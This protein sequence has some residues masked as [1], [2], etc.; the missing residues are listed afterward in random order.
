MAVL[1]V[2]IIGAALVGFLS[3]LARGGEARQRISDPTIESTLAVRRLH[4][5]APEL[6][7]VLSAN[8]EGALL[9]ISD[10]VAS[11][12]VHLSEAGLVRFDPASQ[13]LLLETVAAEALAAD[14]LLEREYAI[15]HYDSLLGTFDSLREDGLLEREILAEGIESMEFREV[16]GSPGLADATFIGPDSVA[17]IRIIPDSIEEPLR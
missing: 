6:R 1:L 13:E 8:G 11:R 5:L 2:A 4:V 15:G 7:S 12:S 3:A 9:W 17:R 10:R 14:R 16:L